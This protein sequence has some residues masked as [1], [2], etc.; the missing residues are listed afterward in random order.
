MNDE[1]KLKFFRDVFGGAW[2]AQ[3]IA[4]TAELGI[5]DLLTAGPRNLHELAAATNSRAEALYRLLRALA[6]VGIFAEESDGRF[7][8]TP[9]AE[10]LRTDGSNS[11]R[12]WAMLM[13]AEFHAAWGEL[14]HSAQTR[15]PGFQ[16]RFRMPFFEY[17]LKHPE[18]HDVYDEAMTIVHGR[19]TE[20]ML[21]AYDFKN[22]R[23][24]VDVGGGK[25][26][27]LAALLRRYRDVQGIL[28]DLPA[29]AERTRAIALGSDIQ[30]RCRV[31]GGDFFE[32]VPR[33]A[34]AYLLRHIVHDWEDAEAVRILRNCREAM[35]PEGKVL[36][37]EMLIPPGNAPGFGKWLDLMMLLVGGRERTFEEYTAL[38]SA[39]GL[40]LDRVIPTS[41]E[42][43][44]LEGVRA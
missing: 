29:V 22:C 35:S 36:V 2:I 31:V 24:V 3:G 10:L 19:E 33:D 15:E 9:L 25:G 21:D 42:V 13:G 1:T 28:F 41:A 16:K 5:A 11:Q 32:A 18:R 34:D 39:A 4:V 30:N 44:V 38:F 8:L 26:L 27:L 12:A 23:T 20:P 37:V 17:M 7:A 14:L 43:Y 6:S 40:R